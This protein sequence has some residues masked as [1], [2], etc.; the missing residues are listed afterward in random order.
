MG[1]REETLTEIAVGIRADLTWLLSIWRAFLFPRRLEDH[2][3]RG[4]WRPETVRGLLAFW[5]WSALGGLLIAVAYPFVLAGLWVRY[6]GRRIDRAA[7]TIGV[8][9]LTTVVAVVWGALSVLA[10]E[11][12]PAAGF[13]AVLAS[14]VVA[15]A[16]VGL[17]WTSARRGGRVLTVVA[18]Y[19]F[20]VAAVVLP[21]VTAAL[22]SPM[23]GRVVLP[24]STSLAVWLLDN[25][26]V[27]VGL[28]TVFRRRFTLSG[29]AFV[30]MWFLI[31][32]PVGWLLG[33]LATLANAV[34]PREGR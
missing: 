21:P 10:L 6:V 4:R 34:R 29:F 15:T 31:A 28:D 25:V 1:A 16:S 24:G 11:R 5:A 26:L 8:L 7:A 13:R 20:A 23:L 17:A 3:A 9:A 19:P 14:S 27:V 18:G 12:L 32:V 22:F 30:G 33:A 2:P